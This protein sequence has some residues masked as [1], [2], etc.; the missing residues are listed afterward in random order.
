MESATD[1]LEFAA[2]EAAHKYM[3]VSKIII[4]LQ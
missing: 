1:L 2:E 4:V 3:D